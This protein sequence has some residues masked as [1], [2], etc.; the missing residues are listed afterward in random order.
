[1]FDEISEGVIQ[2]REFRNE[3]LYFGYVSMLRYRK[4]SAVEL[5]YSRNALLVELASRTI[6][7]P[8]WLAGFAVFPVA[9][10]L[11]D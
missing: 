5:N 7:R 9:S 3:L 1:M 11:D 10:A 4:E 6:G 2:G 8:K